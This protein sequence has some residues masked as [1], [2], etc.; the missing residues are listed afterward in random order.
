MSHDLGLSG[1]P[2]AGGGILDNFLFVSICPFWA[3]VLIAVDVL[4]IWALARQLAAA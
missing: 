1:R 2:R 4:V 3:L